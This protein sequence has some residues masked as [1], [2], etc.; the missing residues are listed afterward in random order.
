MQAIPLKPW[1][2]YW[3]ADEAGILVSLTENEHYTCKC[4]ILQKYSYISDY[5]MASWNQKK[6]E[7]INLVIS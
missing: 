1:T 7:N 3:T 6:T 2:V 4:K 5:G